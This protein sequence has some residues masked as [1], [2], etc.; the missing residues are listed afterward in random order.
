V[1][2]SIKEFYHFGKSVVGDTT[3]APKVVVVRW[4][5]PA[6]RQTT[7]GAVLQQVDH[8]LTELGQLLAQ[9]RTSTQFAMR[10][11][12]YNIISRL[13]ISITS[14]NNWLP[15]YHSSS[16]ISFLEPVRGETN[17]HT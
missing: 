7:A 9:R 15:Y 13:S 12:F 3:L 8:L 10:C 2:N 16:E 4:N 14:H 17:H 5:E 1:R 6:E 11:C